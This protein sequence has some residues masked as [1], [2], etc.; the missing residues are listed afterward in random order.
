MTTETAIFAGGCF[1][2]TEAL[3]KSLKGVVSAEP[4]YIGGETK[5]PT[6]TQVCKGNTGHAEAVKIEF[7]PSVITYEELLSVFFNTHDPT[8]LNRQG[9]DSGTQYRSAIF[10]TTPEQ[11]VEAEKL[12]SELNESKAYEKPVVT[13]V[14]NATEFYVAESYHHDYYEQNKERA[15]C[16]I[17]IA[18]KMAKLQEKY[19]SLLTSITP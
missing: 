15:Y 4:G 14:T 5:D 12:I 8:T 9:N 11:K 17:I 6:Y 16:Q 13:E 18:P 3:L 19:K 10:Y 1:W 7:D 2:C